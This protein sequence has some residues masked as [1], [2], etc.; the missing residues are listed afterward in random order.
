[1]ALPA[2]SW[3]GLSTF[4]QSQRSGSKVEY[5]VRR[6]ARGKVE[7]T[8]GTVSP[9]QT[10]VRVRGE[11]WKEEWPSS[12]F[13]GGPLPGRDGREFSVYGPMQLL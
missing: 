4:N 13:A 1:M 5:C 3:R 10:C 7:T 2:F 12:M 9:N 11:S 8:S 6:L